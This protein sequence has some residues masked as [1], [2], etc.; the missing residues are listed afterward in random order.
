MT[1]P[2]KGSTSLIA[3]AATTLFLVS[4][5]SAAPARPDYRPDG[6]VRVGNKTFPSHAAYFQ[7]SLFRESGARCGSVHKPTPEELAPTDCSFSHTTINPEYNDGRTLVIQVVFHVIKT[8]GGMGDISP[9]MLQSQIDILNED[10]LAL[11]GTPGSMGND[12]KIE[13]V[14]AKFDPQGNPTTGIDVVTNNAYFND[15]GPSAS[16]PMKQALKWDTTRYLNVYTND[17]AGFLGYATFPTQEAGG[18]EDGV[19]LLWTAVGR[20]SPEVPYDQGRTATHEIG[21][22][23]G[24]F[25]TFQDGCAAGGP[26]DS[27][28]L[29]ADTIRERD[30]QFDCVVAASACGGGNN[31]IE[32]YMDYTNDTCMTKFTAEQANRMRCSLVNFRTVNTK[33]MAAFTYSANLLAVTYTST[34]SDAE[35][36][37]EL[38]HYSWDFGDGQTST[39]QSP[40]HTYAANGTY[41]V[42]LTIV[43]PGS[44]TATASQSVTVMATPPEPDA[45]PGGDDDDGP[46]NGGCCQTGGG[47]AS[48]VLLALPV[49]LILR[50]RRRA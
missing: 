19:V 49:A 43:D 13:F 23:L 11:M 6:T 32:N 41:N 39:E 24:L 12:A 7:S 36:T 28:D 21:H 45:D 20:N 47:E 1:T 30:P 46:G 26:Y 34:S 31:P 42:T 4:G 16:N 14:L 17:S 3:A 9:A 40:A 18:P 44:G 8:S 38:L 5:A 48:F 35:T 25:H 22:Y 37:P 10:F 29:I 27:G 15:P 33:P 50:R 2:A